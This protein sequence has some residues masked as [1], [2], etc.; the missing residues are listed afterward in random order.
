MSNFGN[1]NREIELEMKVS[2][3]EKENF[4]LKG[5][6]IDQLLIIKQFKTD[7]KI[8]PFP[9]D[10]STTTNTITKPAQT[11]DN[12]NS[13]N[14]NNNKSKN[15]NNN[16]N[17]NSNNCKNKNNDNNNNNNNNNKQNKNSTKEK[18]V[19][20]EKLQVQLEEIRKEKHT[21]FLNLKT[22]AD[23]TDLL[24][25]NKSN[26][27]INSAQINSKVTD[28]KWPKGTAAIVGDSK[29]SGI[30]EE[31]IKT[32]KHNVKVRFFRGET[33]E[34]MEN[35]IKPILKREPDY[36]IV[37]VRTNNATNLTACDIL[38]KLLQ[39]K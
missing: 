4:E 19:Y 14:N 15:N 7:P 34:H 27:Y 26:E 6:L 29:M 2:L 31:L 13:N 10:I 5:Q 28:V 22:Q 30:R 24:Q 3:L 20:S 8:N 35:N 38:D 25:R 37:H 16:N 33:I 32:D 1:I 21:S 39:L 11:S 18:A 23:Q 9:T 36:I 17:T 12:I